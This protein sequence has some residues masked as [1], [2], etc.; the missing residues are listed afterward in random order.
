MRQRSHPIRFAVLI[1]LTAVLVT[2]VGGCA[3]MELVEEEYDEELYA[4]IEPPEAVQPDSTRFLVVGDTQHSWRAEHRFW[5]RHNWAT[6]WQLAFP[7]YQLTRVGNGFVGGINYLRQKPDLGSRERAAVR[8]AMHAAT[9]EHEPAFIVHTGDMA[10]HDGR[11]AEHWHHFLDE[12][13]SGEASLLRSYPFVAAA[14]NHDLTNDP[15][16]GRP[17][18][19]AIFGAD[20]RFQTIEF[21]DAVLFVVDSNLIVDQESIMTDEQHKAAFRS[22]FVGDETPSWLERQLEAHRDKSLKIIASHH[23]LSTLSWHE[24]DFRKDA[25]GPNLMDKRERLINLLLDHDVQAMLT[26]HEHLYERNQLTACRNDTLRTMHTVI[27]SGGGAIVRPTTTA[28]EERTRKRHYA[29]QGFDVTLQAQKSVYHYTW[30]TIE[31]ATL[32]LDTYEV[33]VSTPTEVTLLDH[34]TIRGDAASQA[35]TLTESSSQ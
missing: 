3:S 24:R 34:V 25:Y 10:A 33:D 7:F 2:S 17:N 19:E 35:C 16:Y 31:G 6:W 9:E 26:G 15:N 22:W 14:G 4:F 21:P 11:Y 8:T 13:G 1:A 27:S 20:A 18:Y 5:R 12:Y 28:E 29:S 30:A 23:P 32:T